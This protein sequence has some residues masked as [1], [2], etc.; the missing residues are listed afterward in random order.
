MLVTPT[1]EISGAIE[2][3]NVCNGISKVLNE[4]KKRRYLV[5]M[6]RGAPLN[7]GGAFTLVYFSL[8]MMLYVMTTQCRSVQIF[9]KLV[10]CPI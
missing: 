9:G 5:T 7:L 3:E 2:P 4:K 1:R 10:Q 6:K 8:F